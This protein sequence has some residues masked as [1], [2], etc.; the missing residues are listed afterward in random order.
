MTTARE[1]QTATLLQNGEV[2]VAGGLN[3]TGFLFSAEL[4]NPAT[5]K[6]TA[7]GSG[8]SMSGAHAVL[9]ANGD[10]FAVGGG[11]VT[12]L[13]NPATESWSFAAG[14]DDRNLFSVT[15]STQTTAQMSVYVNSDRVPAKR[16]PKPRRVLATSQLSRIEL[17]REVATPVAPQ[18]HR[19]PR[20]AA[21][22]GDAGA[23]TCL[24]PEATGEVHITQQDVA[25]A[26]EGFSGLVGDRHCLVD[27][28]LG[29]PDPS[30]I[31]MLWI[32]A[33]SVIAQ[34][35]RNAAKQGNR[36]PHGCDEDCDPL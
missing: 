14:F 27:D 6:W 7:T 36:Q 8:R 20:E 11:G 17:R 28:A 25:T 31:K 26:P 16:S 33:Q 2:L 18:R 29:W 9:L 21:T 24:D 3:S 13:Y 22:G 15:S 12:D 4:Y 35:T 32:G 19:G 34:G 23:Q 5:G 10:V 1:G 30:E